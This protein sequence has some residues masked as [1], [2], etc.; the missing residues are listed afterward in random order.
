MHK[1]SI[2]AKRLPEVLFDPETNIFKVVIMSSE[3]GPFFTAIDWLDS[4]KS[5]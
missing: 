1:L 5:Y 2:K 4:Y 3:N